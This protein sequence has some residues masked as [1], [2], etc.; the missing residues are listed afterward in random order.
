MSATLMGAHLEVGKSSYG[1][2]SSTLSPSWEW[3]VMVI[4]ALCQIT[5]P[6]LP[7]GH[8][9]VPCARHRL[10]YAGHQPLWVSPVAQPLGPHQDTK[11]PPQPQGWVQ[12]LQALLPYLTC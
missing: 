11:A 10:S 9:A 7:P 4:R 5:D 6:T 1:S 2:G 12:S 8:A 3:E